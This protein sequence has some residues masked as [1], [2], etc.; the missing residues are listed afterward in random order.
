MEPIRCR[1]AIQRTLRF[2]LNGLMV[3]KDIRRMEA[4]RSHQQDI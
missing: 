1:L 4:T 2:Q 3:I